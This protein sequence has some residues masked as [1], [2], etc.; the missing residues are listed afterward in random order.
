MTDIQWRWRER[1]VPKPFIGLYQ[2][3]G[4]E[5][6]VQ[7]AIDS[8]RYSASRVYEVSLDGGATW[9]SAP[10]DMPVI[11]IEGNPMPEDRRRNGKPSDAARR[12]MDR[13]LK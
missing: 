13:R 11:D 3:L 2:G 8:G 6:A 7:E 5:A 1:L 10:A 9:H 4:E 12:E